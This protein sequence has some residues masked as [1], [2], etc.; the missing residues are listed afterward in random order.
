MVYTGHRKNADQAPPAQSFP[1]VMGLGNFS[2]EGHSVLRRETPSRHVVQSRLYAEETQRPKTQGTSPRCP[3]KAA[4]SQVPTPC[5]A[6]FQEW[7]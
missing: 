5:P 1:V 7:T 3:Q 6:L 4:T 2:L